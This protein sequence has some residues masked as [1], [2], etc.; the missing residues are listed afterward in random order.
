MSHDDTS[1]IT[2][3]FEVD[4]K[5]FDMIYVAAFKLKRRR[6]LTE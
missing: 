6:N 5:Y 2:D 3:N 4:A 1:R